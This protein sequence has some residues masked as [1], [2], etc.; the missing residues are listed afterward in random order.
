MDI[1]R[2]IE[3]LS[4]LNPPQKNFD[5]KLMLKALSLIDNPQNLYKVIHIAGTNGKG[6]TAAFIESGLVGAGFKVGKFSS[7]HIH[8]INECI[9]IDQKM[10]SDVDLVNLYLKY[11]DL[12]D[13][14]NI[15]LSSFEMLTFLMFIYCAKNEI[16]YLILETGLGGL[17]DSTN[18]VNSEFSVITN[19]SLE[20]TQFLGNN[21]ESIA[22]HKAGIIKNGYTII[23]DNLEVLVNEVKKYTDN[24]VS[25]KDK[26]QII[27]TRLNVEKFITELTFKNSI[28]NEILDVQLGLFGFF[29]VYNFLCAYEV[30][31][32][33]NISWDIIEKSA[34]LTIWQG[35]LQKISNSPLII[36]DAS[37]NADGVCN[38]VSSLSN[39]LP[40]EDSVIICS[41]LIDKDKSEMIN[42]YSKI[43]DSIIFCEI[44]N[45]ERTSD[46]NSLSEL[47]VGKFKNIWK[48]KE[49]DKALKFAQSLNKST[50][51]I[52][53]SCYLLKYFI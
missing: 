12:L 25:I 19:I 3:E 44:P 23:G 14:A 51:V 48:F 50:I 36:A 43:S 31:A 49:P 22:K 30:L 2:I 26:Y 9:T 37:H 15:Y 1:I 10:I 21:L 13:S 42:S 17:D 16:D 34:K 53:G 24:F 33:L 4:N 8:V 52:T 29:Q 32:K 18:V 20:H 5:N 27:N 41:I 38:L 40:F 11:K 47:A 28:T 39:F 7:P 6:S 35:R 46:A 45:Q